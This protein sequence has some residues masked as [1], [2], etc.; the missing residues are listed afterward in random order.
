[1]PAERQNVIFERFIQTDI[2]DKMA[3]EGA[4]L[5]LAISKAY[6]ETLGGNIWVE[7]QEGVGSTFLFTLPTKNNSKSESEY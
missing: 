3:R 7:S 5:G 4:G 2:A 1:M 6:I